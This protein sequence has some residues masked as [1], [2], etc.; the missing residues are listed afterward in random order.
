M[1]YALGCGNCLDGAR[2]PFEDEI[3]MAFQPIFDLSTGGVFAQ[4]ALLRGRDGRGAGEVMAEVDEGAIYRFDQTC[5]TTAIRLAA[6][7]GLSD[8]LSINFLPNAVYEPRACM[9]LTLMVADAL[10]FPVERIIFEFSEVERVADKAHLQNIVR[11][12]RD[13]GFRTAIDDF[14]SGYSGLSL[15]ADV[16]PDIVKLDRD[17]VRGVHESATRR[18]IL[19]ALL[20]M[21]DDLGITVVAEGVEEAAELDT[22]AGM[23]VRLVQGF[24]TA[25][26][27]FEALQNVSNLDLS[28]YGGGA[29][30][31]S[32]K[33]GNF[34]ARSA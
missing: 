1:G 32:A 18:T 33:R 2:L 27:Q 12:Y 3:T 26:P 10:D 23:G 29:G 31:C 6:T 28:S 19:R 14:G 20:N 4:E 16:V 9:Q 22:L 25:R 7:L 11:A 17:L 30:G 13:F 21:C 34:V 8:A 15:I 24:L 5:R